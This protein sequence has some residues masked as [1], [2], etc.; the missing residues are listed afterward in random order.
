MSLSI[1]FDSFWGGFIWDCHGKFEV[2][3][4]TSSSYS[5]KNIWDFFIHVGSGMGKSNDN[6]NSANRQDTFCQY[7]T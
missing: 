4:T 6:L 5:L 3:K 7:A 2:Y 1:T